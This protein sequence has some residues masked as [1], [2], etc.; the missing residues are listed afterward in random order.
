MVAGMTEGLHDPGLREAF[1]ESVFVYKRLEE[2]VKKVG[3]AKD[4]VALYTGLKLPILAHQ[5]QALPHA[6]ADSVQGGIVRA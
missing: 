2:F 5:S 3:R 1:V 4:L 6:R